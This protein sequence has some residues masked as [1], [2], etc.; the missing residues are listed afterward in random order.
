MLGAF[1]DSTNDQQ[2]RLVN[3]FFVDN[4]DC[5]L[6]IGLDFRRFQVDLEEPI[7]LDDTSK[8]P[9]LKEYGDELW[10][11]IL[12]DQYDSAMTVDQGQPG[13]NCMI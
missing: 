7:Q 6:L 3:S 8:I 4:D 9:R 2:V 1:L 5:E 11:M 10:Q 13:P 12:N